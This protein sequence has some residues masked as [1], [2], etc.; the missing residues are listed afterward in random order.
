M[1]EP[2]EILVMF[3]EA[4]ARALL[5]Q[6]MNSVEAANTRIALVEEAHDSIR[7]SLREQAPK[8]TKDQGALAV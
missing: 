1:A 7:E 5:P 8:P 6:S 2:D 4:Q 3:T